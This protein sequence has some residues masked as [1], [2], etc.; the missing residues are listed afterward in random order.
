M[1]RPEPGKVKALTIRI[2]PAAAKALRRMSV[3]RGISVNALLNLMI[4]R[5]VPKK[6][7]ADRPYDDDPQ[8]EE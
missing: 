2:D 8:E 1:K 3:E 6:Y 7:F 5:A 4:D